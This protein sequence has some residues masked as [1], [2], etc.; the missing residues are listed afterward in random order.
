MIK[1]IVE[2]NKKEML[3]SL[4]VYQDEILLLIHNT[5]K[6][7]VVCRMEL[8]DEIKKHLGIISISELTELDKQKYRGYH[9]TSEYLLTG[10]IEYVY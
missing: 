1:I 8:L 6:N 5:E 2:N 9:K 7:I 10:V 3:E 4:S